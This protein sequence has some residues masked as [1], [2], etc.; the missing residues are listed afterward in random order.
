METRTTRIGRMEGDVNY[1]DWHVGMNVVCIDD[2]PAGSL[3]KGLFPSGLER[4]RIYVIASIKEDTRIRVG[5]TDLSTEVVVDV[6]VPHPVG[7]DGYGFGGCRFRPV[8]ERKTD[9][10][11]F[12]ALLNTTHKHDVVPGDAA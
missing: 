1:R 2:G 3:L 11:I 7:G 9:I 8:Q 10:S 12:T 5:T 6:G 4:G